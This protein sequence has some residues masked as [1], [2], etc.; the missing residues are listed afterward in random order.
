[1]YIYRIFFGVAL[2][3]VWVFF[4]PYQQRVCEK[5]EGKGRRLLTTLAGLFVSDNGDDIKIDITALE[6]GWKIIGSRL[7][8]GKKLM[9]LITTY[10]SLKK[11]STTSVAQ[12]NLGRPLAG[13]SE[14]SAS[15]NV[16]GL[17]MLEIVLLSC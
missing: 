6:D 14:T 13:W 17:N 1:M 4:L 5:E 3:L 8:V 12:L 11:S 16:T 7:M 9:H 15:E 10:T 2:P